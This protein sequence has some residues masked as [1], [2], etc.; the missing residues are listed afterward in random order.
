MWITRLHYAG[1][2]SGSRVVCGSDTEQAAKNAGQSLCDL[3]NYP[4][5]RDMDTNM[6]GVMFQMFESYSFTVE[7]HKGDWV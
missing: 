6:A 5:Y 7:E 1:N 2:P 3:M 4:S